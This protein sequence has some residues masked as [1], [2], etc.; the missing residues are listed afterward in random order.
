MIFGLCWIAWLAI[1]AI[2]VAEAHGYFDYQPLRCKFV[3]FLILGL[4]PYMFSV[5][6]ESI[7]ILLTLMHWALCLATFTLI[8]DSLS[9]GR[10]IMG[11]FIALPL[12]GWMVRGFLYIAGLTT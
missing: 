7:Q 8:S 4:C 9:V 11:G 6:G 3:G 5:F 12:L 2:P 10:A 1:L